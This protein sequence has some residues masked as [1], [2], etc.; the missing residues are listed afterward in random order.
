MTG[1]KAGPARRHHAGI[2]REPYRMLICSAGDPSSLG[3]LK[4]GA[5]LARRRSAAVHVLTVATP[6]PHKL[7][8]VFDVAPPAMLDDDSRRAAIEQ[9]REQL[10]TVRGAR[11]WTMRA[12][13][14]FAPETILD[15]ARRWPASLIVLGL[16]SHGLTDRLIGSETAVALAR[17]SPIPILAV[18]ASATELP[19]HAVV[20]IDFSESSIASARLAATMLRPNGRITLI[21]ASALVV[22]ESDPGSMLD[23]Y[24]T[25]AKDRLDEIRNQ[26][27]RRTKRQVD[28]VLAT[29]G[30]VEELLSHATEHESDLIALGSHDAGALE[31]LLTGSIR[32]RVLR[33]AGCSVLVTPAVSEN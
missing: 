14:G 6:F 26:I 18:P 23:L 17:K 12:A 2:R 21:H 9:L 5:V 32:A 24:T 20:A 19:R 1:I 29:G 15:A 27:H 25:G 4:V 30:V 3:A 7:P 31:R 10:L 33:A 16:G 8:S 22:P 28:A 11:S 13:T